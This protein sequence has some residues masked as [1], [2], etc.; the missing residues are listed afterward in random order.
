MAKEKDG[1]PLE[2]GAFRRLGFSPGNVA[3]KSRIRKV[4]LMKVMEALHLSFVTMVD[5]CGKRMESMT[6]LRLKFMTKY[7]EVEI[8][9]R[10][11]TLSLHLEIKRMKLNDLKSMRK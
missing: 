6:T 5:A 11:L 9:P 7:E 3:I 8:F 1:F 2:Y 4:G 10:G